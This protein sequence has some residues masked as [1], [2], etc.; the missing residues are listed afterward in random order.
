M[1]GQLSLSDRELLVRWQRG[2]NRAG[3]AVV[4]RYGS[5]LTAFLRKRLAP[6]E[7][8]DAEQL[9]WL[10]LSRTANPQQLRCSLRTYLFAVARNVVYETMRKEIRQLRRFAQFTDTTADPAPSAGTLLSEQRQHRRLRRAVL[11]LPPRLRR[12]VSLYYW[13]GLSGHR[14]GVSL[15]IPED[16]A[17]S[18]LRRARTLLGEALARP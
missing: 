11:D 1:E 14:V 2:D 4:T 9:V 3:R 6:S 18:R 15:G 5:E 17:R 16:T 13:R 8:Q 10:A 12:V 7:C